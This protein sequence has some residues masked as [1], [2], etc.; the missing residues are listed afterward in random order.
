MHHLAPPNT[1]Q[2]ISPA[3]KAALLSTSCPVMSQGYKL[4][5]NIGVTWEPS[6]AGWWSSGAVVRRTLPWK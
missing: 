6:I 1:P 5:Q 3:T 2:Q 4:K